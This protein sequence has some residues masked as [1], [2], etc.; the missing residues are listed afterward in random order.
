MR[1]FTLPE[2]DGSAAWLAL[3]VLV[4]VPETEGGLWA[5]IQN[6]QHGSRQ[7]VTFIDDDVS[8][9]AGN[10]PALECCPLDPMRVTHSRI[11]F[12]RLR[13][14]NCFPQFS[15]VVKHY[16][17]RGGI[18]PDVLRWDVLFSKLLVIAGAEPI[19]RVTYHFHDLVRRK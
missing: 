14:Q 18:A 16:L 19:Y 1:H 2:R 13:R 4:L 10:R 8:V 11:E 15:C 9:V 17:A 6:L 5:A 3:Q 7:V 12:A